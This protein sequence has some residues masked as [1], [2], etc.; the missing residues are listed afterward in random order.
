MFSIFKEAWAKCKAEKE[1]EKV[2]R[3][4]LVK[5]KKLEA[6]RKAKERDESFA[7]RMCP[8][9]DGVCGMRC[10]FFRQAA[11]Y[12]NLDEDGYWTGYPHCALAV[13]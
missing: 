3:E 4:A 6:E 10:T 2:L 5:E 9:N 7:K 8:I 11:V 12:E 13:S 1:R